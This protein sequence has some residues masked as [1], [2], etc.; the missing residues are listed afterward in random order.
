MT[1]KE[2]LAELKRPINEVLAEKV[3]KA[4]YKYTNE[5]GMRHPDQHVG[6]HLR[7]DNSLELFTE[8]VS[9]LLDGNTGTLYINSNKV[10]LNA[11]S[12]DEVLSGH[13]SINGKLFNTLWYNNKDL[14]WALTPNSKE[15]MLEPSI[16]VGEPASAAQMKVPLSSLLTP[17]RLFLV[18]EQRTEIEKIKDVLNGTK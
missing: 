8:T 6:I 14:A 1:T 12:I 4:P 5:V 2:L 10:V 3:E 9:V 7:D 15:A 13:H 11:A 18:D 16:I 17:Q